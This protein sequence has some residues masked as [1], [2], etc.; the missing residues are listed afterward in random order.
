MIDE[1]DTTTPV[2]VCFGTRPEVIKLAPVI[3]ALDAHPSLHAVNVTTAQHREM[4][5][6][7]LETHGI[8]PD[9]DLGLME[10]GQS[11]DGL[12]SL[13]IATL[14]DAIRE[15]RPAAVVVQGD[16]TTALCA[17]LAAFWHHVPV[18]HVEAGLRTL[19]LASPF[20]EE[21]NR[22]L[23]GSIARWHFCPTEASAV[24]LRREGVPSDRI[25]VTGNTVVDAV[26]EVVRR[27]EGVVSLVPARRR[28]RRLLVTMHRRE[29][30][31]EVQRRLLQMLARL[32]AVHDV[33]IVLPVHPNP[34]VRDVVAEE[35][36][37]REGVLLL[38]PVE[39]AE[40]VQLMRSSDLILTDSGGMQ[41]EAPALGVPL[42]VMRDTTE[43]PEGVAAGC[44]ELCGTD[45]EFV[46][47]SLLKLL[48]D[49]FALVAMA[50]APQPYGDGAA[51]VRI[52]DL[53]AADL[54]PEQAGET[55]SLKLVPTQ[56]APEAHTPQSL[57]TGA[58]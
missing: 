39:Y 57:M 48:A 24:N 11:I 36:G 52:A 55:R 10:P 22:T 26:R 43:R 9:I 18:A 28:S 30:H 13:A 23:I 15:V 58:P 46:E 41:E 27:Q 32:V 40:F 45:P 25:H 5:D 29:T 21:G 3:A 47:S 54:A 16:T 53:L 7:A 19:D 1:F 6:Q 56:T 51:A 33:E 35:L 38:E 49:P 2:M 37:H 17:A 31:G 20:P 50:T 14:G 44:V 12:A 34:A 8:N 42:L 4:L